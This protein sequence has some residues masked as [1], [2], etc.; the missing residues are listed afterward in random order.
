MRKTIS[1]YSIAEWGNY[2]AASAAARKR[3][4]NL[5]YEVGTTMPAPVYA[6]LPSEGMRWMLDT[7]SAHDLISEQSAGSGFAPSQLSN[8]LHL[9]TANGVI[10]VDT[11]ADVEVRALGVTVRPLVLDNVPPVLLVGKRCMREG[12]SFH[13]DA[14][15]LPYLVTPSG[16]KTVL[17]V[18]SNVPYLPDPTPCFPAE[19][20]ASPSDLPEDELPGGEEGY[21]PDDE[22]SEAEPD[23][24]IAPATSKAERLLAEA[25]SL[26][27]LKSHRY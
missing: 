11:A 22:D 10:S 1:P 19:A 13:W 7:G 5:S 12:Y 4:V 27:H 25:T 26:D 24:A 21:L 20:E 8:P 9:S 14:W 6:A 18:R 3:A 17:E 23:S 2:V 16:V 15:S